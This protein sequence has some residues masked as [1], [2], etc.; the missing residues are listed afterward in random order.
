[1]KTIEW[2]VQLEYEK[3]VFYFPH[4]YICDTKV[5]AKVEPEIFIDFDKIA[6]LFFQAENRQKHSAVLTIQNTK[7]S[8]LTTSAIPSVQKLDLKKFRVPGGVLKKVSKDVG[9]IGVSFCNGNKISFILN[10]EKLYFSWREKYDT[11]S[12]S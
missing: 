11:N 8:L 3:I 6:Y 2:F 7:N 12:D 1:M 9:I 5:S 10:P 4:S